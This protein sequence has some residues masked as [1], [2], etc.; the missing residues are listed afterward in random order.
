MQYIHR[1]LH[2]VREEFRLRAL[3]S[4]NKLKCAVKIELYPMGYIIN[5]NEINYFHFNY[6]K[7][8]IYNYLI[9]Y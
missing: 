1:N 7:I 9:G 5:M 6:L 4:A 8:Y 2:G 3:V